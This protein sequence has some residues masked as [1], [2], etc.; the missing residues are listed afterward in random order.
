MSSYTKL[1]FPALIAEVNLGVFVPKTF[2]QV[3][4][5]DPLAPQKAIRLK[6]ENK[7][8]SVTQPHSPPPPHISPFSSAPD[9]GGEAW[10]GH[11]RQGHTP[12]RMEYSGWAP[13]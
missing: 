9:G 1:E 6:C 10:S 3:I 8:V 13:A 11:S 12:L 7:G 4:L 5:R 2:H